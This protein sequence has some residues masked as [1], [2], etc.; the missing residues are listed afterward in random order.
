MNQSNKKIHV[1]MAYLIPTVISVAVA[2][3][4][5]YQPPPCLAVFLDRTTK[6]FSMLEVPL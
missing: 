6:T 5:R 4:N 2:R 3:A 1:L